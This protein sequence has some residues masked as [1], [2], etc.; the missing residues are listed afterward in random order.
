MEDTDSIAWSLWQSSAPPSGKNPNTIHKE[1]TEAASLAHT[2]LFSEVLQT[3]NFQYAKDFC[4]TK[5]KQQSKSTFIFICAKKG[6]SNW[7]M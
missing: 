2:A 7:C 6:F 4:P 5:S 1:A 3:H